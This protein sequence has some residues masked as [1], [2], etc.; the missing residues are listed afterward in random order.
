[1]VV[2]IGPIERA[3]G[4]DLDPCVQANRVVIV[5][6]ALH[7]AGPRHHRLPDALARHRC[8]RRCYQRGRQDGGIQNGQNIVRVEHML[9]ASAARYQAARR[10]I[11][12]ENGYPKDFHAHCAGAALR[13]TGL[14]TDRSA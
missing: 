4:L 12:P 11:N 2:R 6:L 14:A 5:E 8:R 3:V 10:D 13:L 9:Q 7:G 1:M